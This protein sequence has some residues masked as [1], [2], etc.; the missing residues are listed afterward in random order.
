VI[1]AARIVAHTVQLGE[2]PRQVIVDQTRQIAGAASVQFIERLDEGHLVVTTSSGF[3]D[4]TGTRIGLTETSISGHVWRS[5]ETVFVDEAH[6]HPL[7]S[8]RLLGRANARSTMWAPVL[9]DGEVVAIVSI[10]WSQ[11]VG[12]VTQL[13]RAAVDT[14]VSEAALALMSER[15]RRSL[16]EWSMT[17]PLTG[18]LNR[19][20]WE[21]QVVALDAARREEQSPTIVALLDFDHFKAYNDTHGHAAGDT[22]L[23]GFG[24]AVSGARR[25]NDLVARWGGEE[26]AIALPDCPAPAAVSALERL[27]RCV[28]RELTCSVGYTLLR[29]DEE[30]GDAMRRADKA[31][32]A[33]KDSGR[34]QI[35]SD[36]GPVVELRH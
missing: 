7:A 10:V 30:I 11:R 34:N 15:M 31:L 19:R 23:S 17:D 18:L 1:E 9:I 28:P 16:E 2:D 22:A 36:T 33:A 6:S 14:I 13:Q 25:T 32:Y 29:P 26:F 20:G 4:L 12:Q 21:R 5:T 27:T 24:T 8:P 35:R 3:P